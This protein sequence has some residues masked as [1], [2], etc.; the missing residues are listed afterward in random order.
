MEFAIS[1]ERRHRK[2][3]Y[4]W[5]LKL[6]EFQLRFFQKGDIRIGVLPKA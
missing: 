5:L 2:S 4:E 3:E 1:G 6:R